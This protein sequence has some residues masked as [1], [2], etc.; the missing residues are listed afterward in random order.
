MNKIKG[1]E[2][3]KTNKIK[4]ADLRFK[5]GFSCSQSVLSAFSEEF[6]LDL[7]VALKI[8]QPFGGGIA[9]RGD[10]CGAVSGAFMVLGLKYG[11]TA[12]EDIPSREKTYEAVTAFIEKFEHAYGSIICKEL[13]GHDLST[14]LGH[15]KAE[16]EGVFE[17]LCPKFVQTA[18][19]LADYL[20]K[21]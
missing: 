5:E 10:I 17:N 19:E 4:I 13:L 11:R 18:T 16:E 14:N 6:D 3:M 7:N 2:P 8:S 21:P 9:H 12:A 1:S 15:K 20:I